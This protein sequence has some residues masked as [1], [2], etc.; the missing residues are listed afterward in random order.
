MNLHTFVNERLALLTPG[1]GDGL[2]CM[3][4]TMHE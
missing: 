1:G 3:N 2:V 4:D